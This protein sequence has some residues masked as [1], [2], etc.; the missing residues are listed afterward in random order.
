MSVKSKYLKTK[1]WEKY[2]EYN[3]MKLDNL[4][5]YVMKNIYIH[6]SHSS[7]RV[8]KYVRLQ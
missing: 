4:G 2:T 7:V 1:R 5:Y 3:G 6:W 8:A